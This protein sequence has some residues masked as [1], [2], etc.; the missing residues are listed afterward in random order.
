MLDRATLLDWATVATVFASLLLSSGQARAESDTIECQR[1]TDFVVC[2]GQT[3][4]HPDKVMAPD[5][6]AIANRAR[7]I[8]Q[9]AAQ[10]CEKLLPFPQS[11]SD[12][13]KLNLAGGTDFM[14]CLKERSR[15]DPDYWEG[16]ERIWPQ[17]EEWF[18]RQRVV[19]QDEA[20]ENSAVDE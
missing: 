7:E 14:R 1:F 20:S 11:A 5:D 2:E 13:Q 12:N 19:I 17:V 9:R 16:L 15:L 4:V 18:E 10:T 6:Q 8:V 3:Y